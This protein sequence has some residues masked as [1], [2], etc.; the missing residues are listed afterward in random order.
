MPRASDAIDVV[1]T[2]RQQAIAWALV[3]RTPIKQIAASLEISP[4]TV[5]DHIK[6]I[7]R[8][9]GAASTANLVAMLLERDEVPSPVIGGGTKN[10]IPGLERSD[11]WSDPDRAGSVI[12]SDS[13]GLRL[14]ELWNREAGPQV[15][16]EELD[17]P[18]GLLP[19]LVAIGKIVV[20]ILSA[21]VLAILAMQAG[22]EIIDQRGAS[23]V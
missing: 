20:L 18:R 8:K 21:I 3:R 15:V 16:P 19:R 12:L 2:E 17:G 23:A 5:N 14:G 13:M 6:L 7:K 9:F 22:M 10:R 11:E 1:L 4:S